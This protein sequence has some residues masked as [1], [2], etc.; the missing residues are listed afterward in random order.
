MAPE[1][2]IQKSEQDQKTFYRARLDAILSAP[3][4][5]E[6]IDSYAQTAL[7]EVTELITDAAADYAVTPKNVFETAADLETAAAKEYGLGDVDSILDYLSDKSLEIS[8][9]SD[10]IKR[11]T[12]KQEVIIPTDT[13]PVR[14]G[15]SAGSFEIKAQVPRT[16]A[17]LF[18]LK[19]A[20]DVD[21]YNPH[22]LQ[23]TSGI[24]T[25]DMLR[26]TSY[27]M[28]SIPKL[29]RTILVCDEE[30]NATFIF[31][32]KALREIDIE[33]G[34]LYRFTKNELKELLTLREDIGQRLKYT[35]NF[36]ANM[37]AAIELPQG[38]LTQREVH[39]TA[40]YLYPPAP[41]DV[42]SV[43]GMS[44]AFK[45]GPLTINR[46]IDELRNSGLLGQGNT[47]RFGRSSRGVVYDPYEQ[48]VIWTALR[49]R[50]LFA[51]Q[52]PEGYQTIAGIGRILGIANTA[53][54][55]TVQRMQDDTIQPELLLL[56]GRPQKVYSPAIIGRIASYLESHGKLADKPPEGY[57][58]LARFAQSL[59]VSPQAIEIAV[60]ELGEEDDQPTRH[61]FGSIASVSF[62]PNRQEK[63][64]R[65]LEET[66]RLT[67]I[68]P[69]GYQTRVGI[70]Q[71]LGL[72]PITV[73]KAITELGDQLGD[74]HLYKSDNNRRAFNYYAPHQIKMIKEHLSVTGKL[75]PSAPHGYLSL[76]GMGKSF[77]VSP[78]TIERII[79]EIPDL[80]D[81][82]IHKYRSQMTASYSPE[83]QALIKARLVAE[84]FLQNSLD[85]SL[86]D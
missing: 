31:N 73:G 33:P 84:G 67:S 82:P 44:A 22:E 13:Q 27:V 30:D 1:A 7:D 21:I 54:E 69:E 83:K 35:Q 19:N 74:A 46:T 50:G 17:I 78:T 49:E 45:V 61:K 72:D 24:V 23:V 8:R 63:I 68:A 76:R 15:Y 36:S 4:T 86:V 39:E 75:I 71:T 51:D 56:D 66:G 18:L 58:S 60:E 25:K 55:A 9:L 80:G 29:E 37:Q 5:P 59:H 48:N 57:M 12:L 79:R 11:G 77:G 28:L 64:K 34:L 62:S 10:V 2:I 43:R 52:A 38:G 16:K 65:H 41:D 40:S 3:L 70:G 6:T 85:D 14:S 32:T 42:L 47:Y 53:V 26:Q 81:A 20:F